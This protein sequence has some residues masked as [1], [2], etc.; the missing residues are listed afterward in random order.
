MVGEVTF[1]Y[2]VWIEKVKGEMSR[3]KKRKEKLL[4]MEKCL[5]NLIEMN[6]KK[7]EKGNN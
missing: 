6:G 1:Q 4:K 5:H 2:K 7:W 3:E